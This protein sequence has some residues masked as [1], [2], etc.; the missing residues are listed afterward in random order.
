[1]KK[2]LFLGLLAILSVF[3]A[4]A[5]SR[6]ITGKVTD[7]KDG[8]ALPGVTVKVP[9]TGIGTLTSPNGEFKLTIGDKVATL[10]FSFVGYMVQKVNVA[11]RS[12]VNVVLEGDQKALSEVVVVGYGTQERK[13]VTA[14]IASINGAALKNN[15]SPSVD[16]QLAGQVS[17][18]QATVASGVLGQ[19]A[20]IR[21]RGTNSLSSSADPLY[22]IDG[23]PIITGNQSGVTPNN[24]LGDLNPNDIESM[25]V[26]KDGSATAI[27]GSRAA[28]G[29]VL[30]TTKKGKQ[31][32]AKINYDAW[33]A[34]ATPAKK[35]DLLNAEEFVTIANEKFANVSDTSKA[36]L[37]AKPGGGFYDT[38]W[39]KEVMR[40]GFQQNHSLSV[41]GATETTNYYFSLGYTDMNG[42]LVG[43]NQKKYQAR[44]RIE[45]KAFNVVTVGLNANIAHVTN[46]GFNT[47]A[48]ATGNN[49]ASALRALPN[50]PVFNADG[51]YNVNWTENALGQG[52]NSKW[53][54][55]KYPNPRFTLDNNV[56]R[57]KNLNVTGNTF[58]NVEVMKGLN[59]RTQ[60]GIN[61]L[62]GEDYLYWSP[63]HG[64]GYGQK[65]YVMQQYIPSFRYNWANTLSYNKNIGKHNIN[66]V[67][68]F[69]LQ[70]SNERS[71]FAEGNNLSTTYFSGENI[72]DKSL[73]PMTI[74]GGI[75]ERA[76]RSM[77][78][79]ASYAY[80]DRYILSATIR[81]DAISALPPGKQNA[82]LPGVSAG[83]R[84]SQENF[85]KEGSIAN[86]ISNLKIRGGYAKV[87]NVEIGAYPYYGS[88]SGANYGTLN[89]FVYSQ[90]YNPNLTFETSKKVNIGFDLGLLRDRIT[91]TADYFNNNIDGMILQAPV[92]P[93]LGIPN[94]SKPNV[95]SMNIGK[96]YNRGAELSVT[97]INIQKGDFQWTTTANVTFVKNQ[98]QKLANG[99]ISYAYNVTREGRSVG[100]FY[101]YVYRGVNAANGNPI[102]E[103]ADGSLVQASV[104]NNAYYVYD[105]SKPADMVT[106][107]SL[108]VDDKRF[109]G[110]ATPTYYG[111]LNNTVNYKG[112]DFNIFFSFAGG[113]KIMN[114]T[115]QETLNNQKFQNNGKEILNRWT[116]TNTVTDVPKMYYGSD[117]FLLL[118]GNAT[119]RFVEDASFI[120]AQNIGLGYT[121]PSDLLKKAR[122]NSARFYFQVQNAFVI[123]KYSGADPELNYYTSGANANLQP[124]LDM[125]TS[126]IPRTYTFG[127]NI[128]L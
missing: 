31:G 127:V 48:N 64:D 82:N 2:G 36:R 15:A 62:N 20:R 113:N 128:G 81:R 35:F 23:V 109:L 42:M 94:A 68:G 97:S 117:A 55:D 105:A 54:D 79:R 53:I 60:L 28:N 61:L 52:A 45:Q 22:V 14:S 12:S 43:N 103:K 24:P 65:G 124:G 37:L 120:R 7:A 51:T 29:V 122:I 86:V 63:K 21:I 121:V 5:Q 30:I 39:Q 57:S 70:K 56:Y 33:F 95:I 80:A 93:S 32:K 99:D 111:G 87:G 76:F 73:S 18:V 59:L 41:S 91:V 116:P 110:Q 50:V 1:M 34:A 115:R 10:E 26:L 125:S 67:A 106:K 40:T 112:F 83:W 77:F 69:E 13:N 118:T 119:S 114:V 8:S 3:Q 92:A 123:T 9:G 17:G 49:M 58:V 102:Y 104:P 74:G 96:M 107:S 90:V 108:G 101:G 78:A 27:Y 89:G 72:I 71:F 44:M 85:F 98:V 16:R 84:L 88:Y 4:L 38:D 11:N 6:T 47:S 126:P 66:A 75:I 19:P 100:E 25:E 46:N